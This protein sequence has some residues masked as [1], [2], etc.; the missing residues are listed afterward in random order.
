MNPKEYVRAD[1]ANV[2]IALV[3]SLA[4]NL[5]LALSPDVF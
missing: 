3:G 1:I 4:F 2:V 5:V